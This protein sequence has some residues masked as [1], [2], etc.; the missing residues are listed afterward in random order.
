MGWRLDRNAL[1]EID[2]II[3]ETVRDPVGPEFMAPP[4]Q[5]AV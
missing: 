1:V 2:D 4:E 3:R 5:V